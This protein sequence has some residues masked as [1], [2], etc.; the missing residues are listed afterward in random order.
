MSD[1]CVTLELK[2]VIYQ[3]KLL[4]FQFFE[5]PAYRQGRLALEH[6]ESNND[7]IDRLII[8]Y[9]SQIVEIEIKVGSRKLE[10]EA[11]SCFRLRAS[12]FRLIYKNH[13]A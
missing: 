13:F 7:F 12:C 3:S 2:T 11:V 5:S 1:S 8:I 9:V 4:G 10:V 6:S